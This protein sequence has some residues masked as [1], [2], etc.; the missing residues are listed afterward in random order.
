[1]ADIHVEKGVENSSCKSHCCGDINVPSLASFAG[2][3]SPQ[4]GARDGEPMMAR[5]ETIEHFRAAILAE[6]RAD[7][8]AAAAFVRACRGDD[9]EMLRIAAAGLAF[10]GGS[11]W[12]IRGPVTAL[13]RW[14]I[15]WCCI[16]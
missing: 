13:G 11:F 5:I 15:L 7:R 6:R 16:L 9:P 14:Q 2:R 10:G 12:L 1:M 4:V 8:A 3:I